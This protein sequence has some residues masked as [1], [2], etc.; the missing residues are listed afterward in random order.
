MDFRADTDLSLPFDDLNERVERGRM[1][2]EALLF[3]EREER[4]SPPRLF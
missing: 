3:I 1:F 4:N 2:T